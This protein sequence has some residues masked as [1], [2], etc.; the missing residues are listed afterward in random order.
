MGQIVYPQPTSPGGFDLSWMVGRSITSVTFEEPVDW[1]FWFGD[2]GHISVQCPWRILENGRIVC[3]IEDHRQQYGLPAPIDAA[4]GATG[5][6]SSADVV[7]ARLREGT[8][9]ILVEFSG[10]L[11]LEIIPMSSG[12]E[13]W[14][15]TDPFGTEFFAQGGGQICILRR[16]A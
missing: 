1:T 12:Y 15:L 14:N 9:D 7:R 6:L 16:D 10:H 13:S 2:K 3:S 4:A 5:L 8:S 11:L